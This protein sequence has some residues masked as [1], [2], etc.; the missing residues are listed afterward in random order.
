METIQSL[1]TL[2]VKPAMKRYGASRIM[3]L[4]IKVHYDMCYTCEALFSKGWFKATE[5]WSESQFEVQS[6]TIH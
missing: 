3:V 1:P 5:W 6:A 4:F 2:T